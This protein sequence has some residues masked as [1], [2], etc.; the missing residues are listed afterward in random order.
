[1]KK[2]LFVFMSMAVLAACS[3]DDD[4]GAADP[5][6]GTWELADATLFDPDS[7]PEPSIVTFSAGNTGSGTF[8]LPQANCIPQASPGSWENLGS[9]RY[10]IAVPIL[11]NLEGDVTF[12]GDD[13]FI[14][15][16]SQA[17]SFTFER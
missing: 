7:C 3:S 4:A 10:S 12:T 5:I 13:S 16:T 11:G 14:F 17:G 9:S 2:F 15:V 1:M 6:L 8:Y